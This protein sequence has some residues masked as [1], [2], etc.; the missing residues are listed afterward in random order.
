MEGLYL[1]LSSLEDSHHRSE[2]V[3][4]ALRKAHEAGKKFTVIIV[5]ASPRFEG[6]NLLNELLKEGI[7]CVY[8][9]LNAV[10]YVMRGVSKVLVG[11]SGMLSNGQLYGRS[12]T[13]LVCM[14]ACTYDVPVLVACETYKFSE[15]IQLDAICQ[16][17]IEDPDDLIEHLPKSNK[18]HDWKSKAS[19]KLL[20]P[21]YDLT[22]MEYISMVI[23]ELGQIPATSVPV[24][25][26]EYYNDSLFSDWN[27]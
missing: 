16:N 13:A 20:N 15:K 6:R 4:R 24:V 18:I 22:P 21:A 1:L 17:E 9:L 26:R 23:T 10:S 25:I 11:A 5:D 8:V 14:M 19:L 7:D 2:V 3:S 12:G 27:Q